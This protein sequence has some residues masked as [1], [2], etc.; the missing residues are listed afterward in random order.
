MYEYVL[1][2]EILDKT[3]LEKR[4]LFKMG[5][6]VD[7]YVFC[8]E[9]IAGLFRRAAPTGARLVLAADY[10]ESGER[11]TCGASHHASSRRPT[12]QRREVS[13]ENTE[14]MSEYEQQYYIVC[15]SETVGVPYLA[16]DI[17]TVDR[18]FSFEQQPVG[19][20]PYIF[21]NGW[22]ER[23]LKKGVRDSVRPILFHGTNLVVSSEIREALLIL[24]VP[25][26]FMHPAI[27]IDDRDQWHADYWY[28]TFTELFDCWDRTTS[29]TSASSVDPDGSVCYEVTRYS[30]DKA[31]L[32]TTPL[33]HR[34]LFKMGGTGDSYLFCHESIV[35]LFRR[36][37][38]SGAELILVAD[39]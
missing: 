11:T 1:N 14:V 10:W 12:H 38:P 3:P 15:R 4:L 8:H 5:G 23:N 13:V 36:S 18:E 21:T 30:L 16:P 37:A 17:D 31:V 32:D 39:Y 34:L 19:S 7:A 33:P 22:R 26:L 29:K 25:N 20:R 9:S 28:L 6:I 35:G 24:D 27:Y 2:A